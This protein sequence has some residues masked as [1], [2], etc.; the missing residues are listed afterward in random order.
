MSEKGTNLILS[1]KINSTTFPF[2]LTTLFSRQK[3]ILF[4]F[5]KLP[6]WQSPYFPHLH[7]QNYSECINVPSGSILQLILICQCASSIIFILP[8]NDTCGDV[9]IF[10]IVCFFSSCFPLSPFFPYF[11]HPIV[12]PGNYLPSTVFVS[13]ILIHF[14]SPLRSPYASYSGWIIKQSFPRVRKA[15][16]MN[17]SNKP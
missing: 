6:L 3:T 14:L 11:V 1:R 5:T 2:P 12:S 8:S 9:F 17:Y 10:R 4:S 16:Q 7:S 15:F 13:G